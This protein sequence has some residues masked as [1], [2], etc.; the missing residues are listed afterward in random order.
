MGIKELLQKILSW[1]EKSKDRSQEI[2]SLRKQIKELKASRAE[3]KKKAKYY[4]KKIRDEEEAAETGQ[5]QE[6]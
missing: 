1:K 4:Q 3:W 2:K 5:D 6:I